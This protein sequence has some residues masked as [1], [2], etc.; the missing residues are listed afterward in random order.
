MKNKIILIF[1]FG[2]VLRL[3]LMPFT[4]HPD[5]RGHYLGAYFIKEYGEYFS[6]Y[7][8]ISKLP[9][10]DPIVQLYRDDFLVYSPLTYQL[11]ALWMFIASPILPWDTFKN[12]EIDMTKA[13]YEESFPFLIFLLKVPY[14]IADLVCLL[15]LMKLVQPKNKLLAVTLWSL[16]LPVL[17]SAF[18]MGQ[19]DIFIL[20]SLLGALLLVER[21]HTSLASVVL[22]LGAGFKPFSLFLL[23]LIPGKQIKNI[24]IGL[25]TYGLLIAPYALTSPAYRMYALMAQHSDKLWYAKILVSGSQY[26]PLFF[27]AIIS[28][29]WLK[30]YNSKVFTT[31]SWFTLP[32]LAFYSFTHFHPQWF[33]WISGYLILLLIR[34]KPSWEPITALV[35]SW[36]IITFSFESSLTFGLFNIDYSLKPLL[37]DQIISGIRALILAT[38]FILTLK[39]SQH[40]DLN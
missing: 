3:A 6:F 27:V 17:H 19:F 22:A 29:A 12:M 35:I 18:M 14:L 21:K 8:H 30:R 24:L 32:L 33:T 13:S 7:D 1:I 16:N 39:L 34:F 10:E 15:I 31:L 23:P 40:K 36:I 2:L 37:N 26:L 5:L 28:I 9:R 38:S 11:H 25:I 4:S 20:L